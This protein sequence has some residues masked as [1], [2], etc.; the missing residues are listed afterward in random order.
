MKRGEFCTHLAFGQITVNVALKEVL[1][2]FT[3][4]ESLQTDGR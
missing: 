1:G 3:G 4:I 2:V